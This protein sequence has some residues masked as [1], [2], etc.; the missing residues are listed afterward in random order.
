MN[1]DGWRL[2]QRSYSFIRIHFSEIQLF[3]ILP[4]VVSRLVHIWMLQQKPLC[5]DFKISHNYITRAGLKSAPITLHMDGCFL[6][7]RLISGGSELHMEA[8]NGVSFLKSTLCRPEWMTT[9]DK[10]KQTP[11]PIRCNPQSYWNSHSART[12]AYI[13]YTHITSRLHWATMCPQ[14]ELVIITTTFL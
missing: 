11:Q 4:S 9:P 5:T 13:Y 8:I 2:K 10:V 6:S 12:H 3:F 7:T 1:R 14:L